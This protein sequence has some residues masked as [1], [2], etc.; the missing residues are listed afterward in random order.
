MSSNNSYNFDRLCLVYEVWFIREFQRQF[1]CLLKEITFSRGRSE[2][3]SHHWVTNSETL[4]VKGVSRLFYKLFLQCLDF[5]L[6]LS[7]MVNFDREHSYHILQNP[8]NSWGIIWISRPHVIEQSLLFNQKIL[9][10]LTESSAIHMKPM[11]DYLLIL[12]LI[13]VFK[14]VLAFL[15]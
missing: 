15:Q 7:Q 12:F 8:C 10:I 4:F 13:C 5:A 14:I 11:Y 1:M 3:M 2:I 9:T 6:C